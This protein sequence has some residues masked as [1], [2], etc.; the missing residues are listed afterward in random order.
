[1]THTSLEYLMWFLNTYPPKAKSRIA[2]YGGTENIGDTIVKDSL[3]DGGQTDYHALDFDNGID[4]REPIVGPKFDMGIC[5]D[6]LEH[7]SNPFVVAKNIKDSLK[8][9]AYLFV[10]VPFVWELHYYPKDYWRFTPSGLEE[11]FS[12][13]DVEVLGLV[14]DAGAGEDVP[15]TR[16][17]AVFHNVKK[18]EKVRHDESGSIFPNEWKVGTGIKEN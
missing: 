13:M 7:T 16:V 9:G 2:D 11:L 1:M 5:M 8:R 17:V 10:T 6:L 18:K 14:R 15:R 12:D 4:L 3:A